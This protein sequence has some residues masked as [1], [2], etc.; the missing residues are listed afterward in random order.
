MAKTNK[1]IEIFE[2]QF[3]G[4]DASLKSTLNSLQ[5]QFKNLN[6]E[7]NPSNNRGIDTYLNRLSSSY[8]ELTKILN[9]GN[10]DGSSLKQLGRIGE[11]ADTTV[12]KLMTSVRSLQNQME[13]NPQNFLSKNDLKTYNEYN[14]RLL[15]LRRSYASAQNAMDKYS[16]ELKDAQ[17]HLST[18]TQGTEEYEDALKRIQ[19]LQENYEGAQT[20]SSNLSSTITELEQLQSNLTKGVST[21]AT[22][23]NFNKIYT[24]LDKMNISLREYNNL[25][26][27]SNSEWQNQIQLT[28]DVAQVQQQILGFFSVSGGIEIFQR[29]LRDAYETV[30]EL[31]DAMTETAVVTDMT[32]NDLWAQLPDYTKRANELG[33]ATLGAYEAA[34]LYY[35]QGL[36][37]NQVTEVS[38]ETLKMARI[39]NMDAAEA[40]ELMTAALRGF[41]LEINQMSAQRVNDVLSELAAISA[42]DTAQIGTALTRTASIANSANMELETTAS[43]LTQIIE[44]TQEAPETA[45]SALRTIIARFQELKV[46][47]NELV[48][49]DGETVD[50]NKIET[51]LK[52]VGIALRDEVTGQFRD[53]DDVF[54]ELAKKWDSLTVNT[55]RYIATV[56]AGSRQQSRFIAMMSDYDRLME[57]VNASYDAA[58]ASADQFAKTQD[59]LTTALNRLQNQWDAFTMG[60]ANDTIIKTA[61]SGL[62]EIIKLINSLTDLLGGGLLSSIARIGLI[63]GGIF[64]GR[65][66]LKLAPSMWKNIKTSFDTYVKRINLGEPLLDNIQ[67][68]V[69]KGAKKLDFSS[70]TKQLSAQQITFGAGGLLQLDNKGGAL[71]TKINEFFKKSLGDTFT[72]DQNTKAN[73]T[74]Q[75]LGT[76]NLEQATTIFQKYAQSQ[77][78]LKLSGEEAQKALVGIIG[79][80]KQVDQ[81]VLQ[82]TLTFNK[83]S[84]GMIAATFA[85]GGLNTAL[86]EVSESNA[87]LKSGLSGLTT[88][89]GAATTALQ[90]MA[91]AGITAQ[92]A[93]GWVGAIVGVLGGLFG[94]ITSYNSNMAE[95]RQQAIDTATDISNSTEAFD[96]ARS[97][98]ESLMDAAA[99]SGEVTDEVRD[100][101]MELA[102]TYDLEIDTLTILTGKYE[103][104][105]AAMKHAIK[106]KLQEDITGLEEGTKAQLENENRSYRG[107]NI[108]W[109]KV[110]EETINLLKQHGAFKTF[111]Y[112]TNANNGGPVDSGIQEKLVVELDYENLDD[113][114]TELLEN[115]IPE[116]QMDEMNKH[117]KNLNNIAESAEATAVKY[118]QLFELETNQKAEEVSNYQ[119]YIKYREAAENFI[120]DQASTNG[121]GQYGQDYV[122]SYLGSNVDTA[123]FEN[124]YQQEQI[125]LDVIKNNTTEPNAQAVRQAWKDYVHT[126]ATQGLLDAI[127]QE[128]FAVAYSQGNLGSYKD[129]IKADLAQ[130]TYARDSLVYNAMGSIGSNLQEAGAS[131]AD[132]DANKLQELKDVLAQL[133]P[134]YSAV[135]NA[136]TQL[137]MKMASGTGQ[138][139]TLTYLLQTM[140]S[141]LSSLQVTMDE[142]QGTLGYTG[143]TMQQSVNELSNAA[144]L[145]GAS[146]QSLADVNSLLGDDL[147]VTADNIDRL[148]ELWPQVLEAAE[149]VGN[150]VYKVNQESVDSFN[151]AANAQIDASATATEA[152]IKN[153]I[154]ELTAQQATVDA[155]I[156]A[157]KAALAQKT[158]DAKQETLVRNAA[159]EAIANGFQYEADVDSEKTKTIVDNT[160]YTVDAVDSI[161]DAYSQ[162][163]SNIITLAQNTVESWNTMAD[164][165]ANYNNVVKNNLTTA[166]KVSGPTS[167]GSIT[168]K[169][170]EK[171][172]YEEPSMEDRK[173]MLR[174]RGEAQRKIQAQIDSIFNGSDSSKAILQGTLNY[175]NDESNAIGAQITELRAALGRI[176]R[177][178]VGQGAE[179]G[180]L[181]GTGGGGSSAADTDE[182]VADYDKFYNLVEDI[183]ETQRTI[184]K[185]QEEYDYLVEDSSKSSVDLL[186]NIKSQ[187]NEL[188]KVLKL[189]EELQRGRTQEMKDYLEQNK[190]MQAFATYNFSDQTIEID[191]DLINANTDTELGDMID[192]YISK[193]EEIQSNMESIEDDIQDT[194]DA[195]EELRDI[196]KDEYSDFE[197][198]IK[199]AVVQKY[200]EQIDA[201]SNLNDSINNANSNLLDAIQTTIENERQQRENEDAEEEMASTQRRISYLSQD[202]S[203]A[204]RTQ[205]LQ[206]QEQLDQQKESYTDTL[207]DQKITELQ[208][209]NDQAQ[210]AREQQIA[211]L[212]AQ[213]EAYQETGLIWEEVHAIMTEG[214]NYLGTLLQGSELEEI[215]KNA[216]SWR[217][218]SEIQ[219]MHWL[220]DL[221]NQMKIA[222]VYLSS[223][224]QLESVGKTSGSITFTDGSGKTY[225]G[226]VDSKGNVTVQS[227]GGTTKYTEVFQKY[228]GTY[229]TY[230][231]SGQFT[232]TKPPASSNT[233]TSK[234]SNSS[235]AA[236]TSNSK[237]SLKA[238]SYVNVKSGTKWYYTSGG[239][240]PW[241]YARSGYIRY[242]NEGAAYPYNI[243]GLGWIRKKDIVGYKTGGLADFT[244]P[245][246][247]DGTKSRPELVLNQKDTQNFLVLRDMLRSLA[248]DSG[249]GD[250]G[251]I[252][253]SVTVNVSELSNGYDVEKLINDIE[254]TLN[255][256]ARYRNV[257]AINL[258]K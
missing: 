253:Y 31:D 220:E 209:Q 17:A 101:A 26:D 105:D 192:E 86:G 112:Q 205:I 74:D 157:V 210:E 172:K 149:Y 104:L 11:E 132:L 151:E 67:K 33:V 56:A 216:D 207:I 167:Q 122:N 27:R 80:N 118:G 43:L 143:A 65:N 2:T 226:T 258:Q 223:Q 34:T 82:S 93:L 130:Q 153:S 230:E 53:L 117:I 47:P 91:A 165:A 241:G 163:N 71:T 247:L 110:D 202:T 150:G 102:D 219:Q 185:L 97:S 113:F 123:S 144:D 81:S 38:V 180:S 173:A 87:A 90:L 182:W 108:D 7:I 3:E 54:L 10:L 203:G 154:E 238:G 222:N 51:A 228:D 242:T 40:T 128:Q 168:T 194:K 248:S 147:L 9:N 224:K 234:P 217:A 212:Q 221:Q 68:S 166:G 129:S 146:K 96:E 236:I 76:G 20:R 170:T 227:S 138:V 183:A 215:L 199:D 148:I 152:K 164:A 190:Q 169:S 171:V 106:T 196:G 63:V 208:N 61:V 41:N 214:T 160:G 1:I 252:Y 107:P 256:K 133:P 161:N 85:I 213:L 197:D 79:T 225:T 174:E 39:A 127:D 70:V 124:Q 84:A 109:S 52:S 145:I 62:S 49:V 257:N 22:S 57:L 15:G 64:A 95:L 19:K 184:N 42:A 233:N 155:E 181:K 137:D 131:W 98:Y 200:Q 193:L 204:N 24:T 119:D 121:A 232:P 13:R 14:T 18:L 83:F 72:K 246:W 21:E 179:S 29:A 134:L 46:S 8:E 115:V 78:N 88:G 235:N 254:T 75:L 59:S 135:D 198:L 50:A 136:Q 89:F 5:K 44:T 94:L 176:D 141:S 201:L 16:T 229:A 158:L 116:D 162:Q 186:D 245:A 244:G 28:Q 6:A 111:E 243:E 66:A 139:E 25:V 218:L 114:S 126:L 58:G 159:S 250:N 239:A 12:N 4:K 249:N 77:Y 37:N 191:W 69:D 36:S 125:L 120:L 206:L 45:G 140:S 231:T 60:L 35:Q 156:A 251:N 103:E 73:I 178:Y 142:T 195:V 99:D 32:V 211:L 240:S 188:D 175:L 177:D 55:Q 30:R 100:A 189:Q 48:E 23:K 237:P 255:D 187:Y 92:A